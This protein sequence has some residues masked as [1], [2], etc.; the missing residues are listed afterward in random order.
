[1]MIESRRQTFAEPFGIEGE[2]EDL[3]SLKELFRIL[4]KWL[5]IIMLVMVLLPAT[6]VGL[7]LLQTPQYQATIQV[8]IG[9]ERGISETPEPILVLTPTMAEGI[10]SRRVAEAVI[11]R[12]NLQMAPEQLLANLS[13]EPLP[14]TVFV[15][16]NY[17]DPDPERAKRLVE[18]VGAAFSNEISEVST[19]N[20]TITATVW[21]QAAVPS[22]PISPNSVQRG[23]WALALGT[24]LGIGLALLLEQ[25]DDRWQSSDEA[26]QISGVPNL[27]TIPEFEISAKRDRQIKGPAN[28]R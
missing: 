19:E 9:Q 22:S 6:V 4:W 18:A 12:Q 15:E 26:E 5:G 23:M 10:T 13:A 25:F 2:N 27:G 17:T 24:M 1:M 20:S 14:E 3:F 11:Q 16:V 8:L 28:G 21:E 7:S